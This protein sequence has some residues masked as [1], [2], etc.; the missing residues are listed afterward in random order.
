MDIRH[1]G[2]L[3]GRGLWSRRESAADDDFD[4]AVPAPLSARMAAEVRARKL[5]LRTLTPAQREEFQL[6]GYFSVQVAKRGKYWI[7]PSTVFNVLHAET[8]T[9][10]CAGPRVEV[11]LSDLMLAQKLVLENDPEAF[12]AVANCRAELMPGPLR[13][14]LCPR[15]V[16]QAR[17][18]SS[19]SSVRWSGLS[20][21]P[22][23]NRLQ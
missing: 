12:F 8:G 11:P 1:L 5:L 20:T 3:I 10:Y 17:W 6:R 7:L 13:E 4:R 22:R 14:P 18:N 9:S 19:A 15:R 21:I 2:R 23:G 16:L